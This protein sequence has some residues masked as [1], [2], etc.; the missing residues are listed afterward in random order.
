LNP[1][2]GRDFLPPSRRALGP[3]QSSKQWALGCFP[4]GKL[5]KACRQ[6]PTPSSVR[7]KTV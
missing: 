6:P 3:T 2:G 5:T 7:L 4:G 1:S